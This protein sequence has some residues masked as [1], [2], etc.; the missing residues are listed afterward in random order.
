MLTALFWWHG[1]QRT[2]LYWQIDRLTLKPS[3]DPLYF[4][5]FLYFEHIGGE[6]FNTSSL[7][8]KFPDFNI[9]QTFSFFFF[10]SLPHQ[11]VSWVGRLGDML[12]NLISACQNQIYQYLIGKE[13]GKKYQ[14]EDGL[15]RLSE[16]ILYVPIQKRNNLNKI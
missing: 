9:R 5:P 15:E 13:K 3:R 1:F 7:N 2:E 8:L 11:Y 12:E 14:H 4:M 10:N 16:I 6:G